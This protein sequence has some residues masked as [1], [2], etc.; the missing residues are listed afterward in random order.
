MGNSDRTLRSASVPFYGHVWGFN[1]VEESDTSIGSFATGD[2]LNFRSGGTLSTVNAIRV[3]HPYYGGMV[4]CDLNLKFTLAS[5]DTSK[6][7]RIAIGTFGS[8]YAATTSY[9]EPF[10]NASHKKITGRDTPYTIAAAG[11]FN[12]GKLNLMPALYNRADANYKDD[13]FVILLCFSAAP[14]TGSGWDFNKFE[15][16][17]T[18]L[19]GLEH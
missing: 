13:G 6:Q 16:H 3:A 7:F 18:A 4:N 10:I 12:V 5:A 15:V 19:L 14:S 11:T 8:N 17:G 2:L 9:T 1:R